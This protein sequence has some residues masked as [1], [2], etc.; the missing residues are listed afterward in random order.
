MASVL[1]SVG[2]SARFP[3]LKYFLFLDHRGLYRCPK[4]GKGYKHKP[5]LY[6]HA[7][8]ECDGISHFVC[9]ICNKAYTQKVTLKQHV[10]ALHHEYKDILFPNKHDFNQQLF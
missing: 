2:F 9:A 7:K 5:N 3:L 4:C 10:L 6:R 1:L 8:Y